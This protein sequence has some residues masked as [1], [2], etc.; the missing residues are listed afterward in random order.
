V[1]ILYLAYHFPPIGGASV[2]RNASFVRNLQ[3][4]GH[5]VAVVTGP[6]RPDYRWTPVDESLAAEVPGE[7]IELHR[8]AGPEPP[9]SVGTRG[10]A[11]RWLGVE[12]PWQRWWTDGAVPAAIAAGADVDVI[13]ASIAPYTTSEAALAVARRLR[14]PLVVDFEDPWALDEMLVYPTALHRRAD[15]RRMKRLVL[16]ADAVIMNTSEAAARLVAAVPGVADRVSVIPNGFASEDFEAPAPRR[17]DDRF[18]IVHTGSLHTELG[19]RQRRLRVLRRLL[20]GSIA[21]V[22][23]LTRSH[24]HLLEAVARASANDAV[25]ERVEVHFAGVLTAADERVAASSP[26]VR[27]HGFLSHPETIELI[28][29]ADLLFLPMHDLPEGR[30]ATIV[31]CKTYEYVASG[32]PIL[33][34]VPEGD[35]RDLLAATETATVCGPRDVGAMAGVIA[36]RAAGRTRSEA[37]GDR[38][39]TAARFEWRHLSA[40][41]ASV[42]ERVLGSERPSSRSAEPSASA[43]PSQMARL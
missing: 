14:K 12:S 23:F 32:R 25:R 5:A 18:R 20:G 8:V 6:G 36:E 37:D 39:S 10:R 3:A 16:H 26:A 1:R 34:A 38:P 7:E 15:L 13:H 19:E 27:M 33:A 29:S 41:L 22:D 31:P 40:E 35:A 17:H 30:R 24:V 4:L 21:G 43:G 28:R 42:Y 2:L 9:R 11:E